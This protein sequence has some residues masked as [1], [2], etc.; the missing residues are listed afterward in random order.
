M[1]AAPRRCSGCSP[2]RTRLRLL[3]VLAQDR[4][5]VSELTG[6]LGVAQS[7]VSR[8]LGLLKDA[9]LVAE[10]REAGFVYYRLAR[11]R[12]G[13]GQPLLWTLLDAQF[14]AAADDERGARR[15]RAAAGGAAAP[16]GELRHPRR[17]RASWCPAAAGRPG[18]A[19]S[20]TCCRRSTSPTSAA[21][22]ATWPLETARWARHVTGIDRSDEVLERAKALAARR[23]RSPTSSGRRATWRGCRCATS[24]IDVALLSQS[25]HHASDPERAVAE[26]GARPAAGRPAAVLDLKAHDQTWVRARFGDRHLGFSARRARP[27]CSAAAG[28]TARSRG[29][30]RREDRRPVHRAHRERQRSAASPA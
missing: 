3:R 20:A 5:N 27:T 6:I 12:R 4:F 9:G 30:R 10:E 25:L 21:A 7:G 26:A 13:D 22:R 1:H 11:R 14:A 19:R 17:S 29:H 28:L 8:H 15:R 23:R 18:R 24:S 16:Q 2:T